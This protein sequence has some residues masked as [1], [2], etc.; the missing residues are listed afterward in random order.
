MTMT[1]RRYSI[2]RVLLPL[3][4]AAGCTTMGTGYG[5]TATGSNPV[6]FNWKSSGGVDGIMYATLADGSVYTGAYFQ[7]TDTTTDDTLGPL[8]DGW[9]PG[10]GFGGWDYWDTGPDFITHYTG[11]VVANL[12]DPEGKHI[13]CKFRLVHPSSGMASGGQGDCQLPDGKTIET[14]FPGAS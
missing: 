1:K 3:L 9:G 8:W 5:T 7:V 6:R 11:R 10:W 14:S 2:L 12:V 4:L 13:R